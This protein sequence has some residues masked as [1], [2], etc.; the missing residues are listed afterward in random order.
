MTPAEAAIWPVRAQ[1]IILSWR[2][3]CQEAMGTEK[4]DDFS[5]LVELVARLVPDIDRLPPAI[6]RDKPPEALADLWRAEVWQALAIGVST[7]GGHETI[8]PKSWARE[9]DAA[10]RDLREAI[11][12][13]TRIFRS[14]PNKNVGRHLV[15]LRDGLV[16]EYRLLAKPDRRLN[17]PGP[18]DSAA[19]TLDKILRSDRE[20]MGWVKPGSTR[21][22]A[23]WR[24]ETLKKLLA[25]GISA[26]GSKELADT[27]GLAGKTPESEASR[28]RSE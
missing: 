12:R 15:R 19:N 25:L 18:L 8:P 5:D 3:H 28:R 2:G 24:D 22:K 17:R 20:A 11:I 9:R 16:R 27:A 10:L 21:P 14:H 26:V 23:V 7:L 6:S 4:A 1:E 13:L